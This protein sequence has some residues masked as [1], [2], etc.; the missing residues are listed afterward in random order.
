[1]IGVN[2]PLYV[3]LIGSLVATLIGKL[4][5]GGFGQNIFNPAGVGRAFTVLAFGGFIAAQIPDVVTGATPNTIM[6]TLGWVITK[7]EAVQAYLAQFHGLWGLFSGQYIGALGETNTLLIMA[8]GVY[9]SLRKIID[10]RVPV[11]FIGSLFAFAT[12]IMVIKGMGWW[13]PFFFISTGGAM[14]GAVF[15]L[16]DPVTSPTS[17]PGRIIFAIGVAFLTTLIRVKGN[18]PEGVIRSILFMNMLTPLIDRVLDGWPLKSMKRYAISIGT[19][20]AISLVTILFTTSAISYIEPYVPEEL[21]PSLGDPIVFSSFPAGGNVNILSSTVAGDITTFILESKGFAVLE[22]DW[23]TN[24]KP[25]VIEVKIN[26]AAQTIVSVAFVT[27]SD[28]GQFE[29]KTNH[30]IFLTQFSGLSLTI[31]NSVDVS[32][33]AT[34]T[35]ESVIR[36]V[37]KAISAIL[38]PQ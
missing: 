26:T 6:E 34:Y 31:D 30:S 14:F 12:V 35:V 20:T 11:V 29:Y 24:P 18:L 19:V 10:W 1:M 4:I 33:G 21:K 22:A 9:L 3:I 7:P 5:F 8:V 38:T 28:T 16:T 37:N 15:M 13:Y 27:F 2:K 17:I 23:E 36:A 32:V 25:N